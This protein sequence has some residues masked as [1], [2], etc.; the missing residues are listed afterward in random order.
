MNSKKFDPNVSECERNR[1]ILIIHER[2]LKKGLSKKWIYQHNSQQEHIHLCCSEQ[3]LRGRCKQAVNM[4]WCTLC[5]LPFH[6]ILIHNGPCSSYKLHYQYSLQIK[7]SSI[8]LLHILVSNR[9]RPSGF[10]AGFSSSTPFLPS[11]V[12]GLESIAVA[13]SGFCFSLIDILDSGAVKNFL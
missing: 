8:Q 11:A 13:E 1:K 12:S 5:C 2:N 4:V 3:S 7:N 10:T 9:N 6:R